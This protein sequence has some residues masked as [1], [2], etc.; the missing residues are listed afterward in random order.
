LTLNAQVIGRLLNPWLPILLALAL[1]ILFGLWIARRKEQT[2]LTLI[3]LCFWIGLWLTFV[4]EFVYV[5]DITGTRMNT[6]F[7]FYY[8]A[9][10]LWSVASAAGLF[11]LFSGPQRVVSRL[12]RGVLGVGMTIAV[13]LGLFYPAL[14]IPT[15]LADFNE[16]APGLDVLQAA[17]A[18]DSQTADTYAAVQWLNQNVSGTPV[19]LQTT[20]DIPWFEPERARVAAWTGLPTVLGWYNHETQWRGNTE[21]QQ[22]RLPDIYE[23]Y[24]TSDETRTRELLQKYS[25]AYVF[26]GHEEQKQYPAEALAKFDR[27]FPVVFQQNGVKVYRV[28]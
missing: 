1:S 17:A 26:V 9:W 20:N 28:S 10:V 25:V 13:A 16:T 14:A 12:W 27:M 21:L 8:Q 15:R 23:I 5:T 6:V 19:V 18:R 11:Y 7:K 2:P 22:Q 24:S 3:M 4:P